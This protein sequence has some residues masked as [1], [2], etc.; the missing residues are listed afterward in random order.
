MSS[1]ELQK[2][3]T[4][5]SSRFSSN[6]RS[7]VEAHR[8]QLFIFD[9]KQFKDTLKNYGIDSAEIEVLAVAYINKLT[10]AERR[11]RS[12]EKTANVFDFKQDV[13]SGKYKL[14]KSLPKEFRV[15]VVTNKRQVE[16]IK[17]NI[18]KEV[19]KYLEN[20]AH[21]GS[22][23]GKQAKG[24]S[25][26][27]TPGHQIGHGEFGYAVS[28]T[29]VLQTDRI[30]SNYTNKSD[31]LDTIINTYKYA[32]DI[33]ITL[34]VSRLITAT[35]KLRNDYVSVL[36]SEVALQNQ[37]GGRAE[38][39]IL[40]AFKAAILSELDVMNQQ[41]SPSLLDDIDAVI[42]HNFA[43]K[44]NIKVKAGKNKPS[45]KISRKNRVSTKSI[46]DGTNRVAVT[47]GGAY[48]PKKTKRKLTK[49]KASNI[50]L[51]YLI[52]DINTKLHDEIRRLMHRPRLVYRTGRFARSARV[53][54][55]VRTPK[56]Y[57]SIHYTYMRSPYQVFE[58]PKGSS[59]LATPDRDPRSTIK[60]AIR[61]IATNLIRERFY[62]KRV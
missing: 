49:A 52:P 18:G 32:F 45:S 21:K 50:N 47:T 9:I 60:L 56:G 29:R 46:I 55:I 58:F 48:K 4:R 5:V 23:S 36:S 38:K 61:A 43:K 2:L 41:G 7:K 35:G 53:T 12:D 13:L 3:I 15:F 10:A 6:L 59:M 42:L 20:S 1:P 37:L 62:M 28:A 27:E 25:I 33:D 19:D 39:K 16:L 54:D 30:L 34:D 17:R 14:T 31:N 40:D 51:R 11:A 26:E 22:F 57:P 24:S 44:R 8:G